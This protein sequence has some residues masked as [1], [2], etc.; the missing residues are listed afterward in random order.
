MKA[1][2][3]AG[4]QGT[5]LR[6]LTSNVPKP[7]VA[8]GNKP[9]AEHI[10]DLL[11][12]HGIEHVVMTVAFM[13]EVIR[14]HFGDGSALGMSI[15]YAV[16][17][18]PLGTAG[19]VKNAAS[20][21]D[22]TFVIISGDSLT[23]FDLSTVI[24]FHRQREAMVTIALKSVDNPL[25]FGVVIVDE[26]GRIERFLEKPGWGQVFSDT[27]NTGIYVMEPEVLDHIPAGVPY[28]FSHELFPKLFEMRKPLYGCVLDGYWQ[29]IG[30]LEQF[31][32]A[33]R[34][35]LDGHIR[36]QLPGVRLRGNIWVGEGVALDSLDEVTGP[37]LIGNYAR[38]ESG[39]VLGPHVVLGNNVVV[40]RGA[41]VMGSVIGDNSYVAAGARV[42]GAVL[43]TSVDIRQNAVV[44]EG[45]VIGD[46]CSVGENAM[47]GNAVKVYPHKTIDPGS[48]VNSSLIWETKGASAL[49]GQNG[50]R[51]LVNV[52]I[53][54]E[55]AMRLAMSYGTILTK[56]SFV[57]TSR[58]SHPASR[59]LKRSVIAG[60]NSAGIS[61]LD[62]EVVPVAVN[63]FMLQGGNAAGGIHVRMCP[64]DAEAVEILFSEPP[65]V[66][67]SNKRER[68]IENYYHREDFRRA[69]LDEIGAISYP[70]RLVEG[71][72]AAC[73]QGWRVGDLNRRGLRVAV[74]YAESAAG[75]VLSSLIDQLEIEALVVSRRKTAGTES[76]DALEHT[77][78]QVRSME[79]DLG[80]MFDAGA[81]R[82]T[83][84]DEQGRVVRPDVLLALL[85]VQACRELGPG[86]VAL[87]LNVTDQ[88]ADL[89]MESG[90]RVV[91]TKVAPAALMEEA[92]RPDI[93][94]AGDAAGGVIFPR[95]S[96]SMDAVYAF[97]KVLELV[98][99]GVERLS[100][101][102]A[103]IPPSHV[104]HV[105]VECPWNLKGTVM[106]LT[107]EHYRN[108]DV[109]LVD[110]VKVTFG[111]RTWVQI[112]PDADDPLFHV[113]AEAQSE[114]GAATLAQTHAQRLEALIAERS[115]DE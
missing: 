70:A 40:K 36:L 67:I 18:S 102:V 65:G 24:D 21:L 59:V 88:V 41:T 106:R 16:E 46:R 37:A 69:F 108:E 89:V 13:S 97:G 62:L 5:R 71:Y 25:E 12:R 49:F 26:D 35:A 42:S 31:L 77:A 11:H 80:I 60:L 103:E 78:R 87:P 6:P 17:E 75:A 85:A 115:S 28:D 22:D 100:E 76:G 51:G 47:V 81:E 56:G 38:V 109:S 63:R 53:T 79:A 27:I 64:E 66:P 105:P 94:F 112:L 90:S 15:E 101:L 74:D 95:F 29:D 2:V 8:V 3:M 14:A 104:V 23:D 43:G 83:V 93:I 110:G 10:L 1:V 107:V 30:S 45:A 32:Q 84:L 99:S 113:Y 114:E 19:S 48:T 73:L 57:A 86:V 4:G 54:P 50:V 52:D 7:M 55:M 92:A 58:D 9:T 98:S 82:L 34:D 61:V 72:R 20:V 68:S 96:P 39:A 44:A 33:N 111:P 91:R